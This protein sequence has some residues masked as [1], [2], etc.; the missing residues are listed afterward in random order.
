MTSSKV[1]VAVAFFVQILCEIKE[2]LYICSVLSF[3]MMIFLFFDSVLS[4]P[5]QRNMM[6]L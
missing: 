5:C 2:N 6:T 4:L 3:D 1:V